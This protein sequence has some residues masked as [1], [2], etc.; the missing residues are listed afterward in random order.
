MIEINFHNKKYT[1]ELSISP[2]NLLSN[3]RL[4]VLE[5]FTEITGNEFSGK[6]L[7][8]GCAA[9]DTLNF[10]CFKLLS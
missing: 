4:R 9:M 10:T 5:A 6:I 8:A 3:P 2:S 7:D 1:N